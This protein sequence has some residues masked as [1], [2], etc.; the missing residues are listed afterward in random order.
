MLRFLQQHLLVESD[1][2]DALP[3]DFEGVAGLVDKLDRQI[4]F[5]TRWHATVRKRRRQD[6]EH[7]IVICLVKN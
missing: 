6:F 5:G 4:S 2:D 3:G 1:F 7:R